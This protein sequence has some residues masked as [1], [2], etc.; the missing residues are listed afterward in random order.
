[1]TRDRSFKVQWILSPSDPGRAGLYGTT[2]HEGR[3]PAAAAIASAK[4]VLQA[5]DREPRPFQIVIVGV[6]DGEGAP[7]LLT[8]D[9]LTDALR[10]YPSL[11]CDI[12]SRPL[13]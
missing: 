13:C 6:F 5:A 7:N 3:T 4:S 9:D 8:A 2:E 12:I 10:H 11:P 1:M